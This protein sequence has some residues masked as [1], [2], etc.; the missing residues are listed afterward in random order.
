V[1]RKAVF[2]STEILTPTCFV[3]LP[4]KLGDDGDAPENDESENALAFR[5]LLGISHE[6]LSLVEANTSESEA[7]EDEEGSH[8]EE[9]PSEI[10]SES[11]KKKPRG[12]CAKIG[13]AQ[14]KVASVKTDIQSW[15]W[16]KIFG[17][18][19]YLYLVD[20][21]TGK[22]VRGDGPKYP[23]R[24][25]SPEDNIRELAPLMYLAISAMSL[26]NNGAGVARMFGIPWPK[27]PKAALK[28]FAKSMSK[29]NTA[30]EFDCLQASIGDAKQL[31]TQ[32]S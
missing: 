14:R 11:Q 13:K 29:A 30:Q 12:L 6:A 7:E 2:E 18:P 21:V 25:E 20:E 32:I 31:I 15:F 8:G 28:K 16:S 1:L 19:V 27:M 26:V 10:K 17:K 4:H 9:E 23:I 3:I 22:P 24:I 5:D